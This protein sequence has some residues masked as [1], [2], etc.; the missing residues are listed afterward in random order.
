MPHRLLP[1]FILSL[2]CNKLLA[3]D[4][5]APVEEG[6]TP[7]AAHPPAE[8]APVEA[9][10]DRPREA[11][12]ARY[13]VP[14]AWETS[15]EEPL[16]RAR[17]FMAEVLKA[18]ATFAAQGP[19]HFAPFLEGE[20]PRATV[21]ACSDSRVQAGA[22][23]QSPENDDYTVRNLGNQLATSVGSVE[24]GVEHLH[25]PVLLVVGHTGC[26]AVETVMNKAVKGK[27]GISE[28]LSRMKL[29]ERRR[30]GE[31]AAWD[32]LTAAVVANVDAQVSQA[33]E[34]FAPFVQAGELTVVGAVYDLGNDFGDGHG[35][36]RIVNVNS[37]VEGER[38]AAFV[39]A[40]KEPEKPAR[41]SF[42]A[43]RST[44]QRGR[45]LLDGTNRLLPGTPRAS[46]NAVSVLGSGGFDAV[47]NGTLRSTTPNGI[48]PGT[49]DLKLAPGANRYANVGRSAAPA[50]AP[51]AADAKPEGGGR[52]AN[53]GRSTAP[54]GAGGAPPAHDAT[55]PSPGSPPG[56][57][58]PSGAT[59]GAAPAK[60]GLPIPAPSHD[61]A[62]PGRNGGG[63][64]PAGAAKPPTEK[65]EPGHD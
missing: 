29:P 42:A 32:A 59:P 31:S 41:A 39:D 63:S 44:E 51:S 34:H 57:H 6:K 65:S 28:E 24:Y 11:R 9:S 48:L 5:P 61:A 58:D 4:E 16:A 17:K 54:S 53:V 62:P 2:G 64:G 13:G 14:F 50:Q 52:Y 43:A 36:L 30:G 7:A 35:R 23:D 46:V 56:A 45:E 38:L 47:S 55:P 22:W 8:P 26:D 37:N 19:D 60:P 40:V 49:S 15:P 21:L 3:K 27:D 18:N 1:F 10:G 25:T 12:E 33:V 20:K